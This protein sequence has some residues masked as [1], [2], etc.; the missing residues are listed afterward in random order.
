MAKA[1][2]KKQG[3][4]ETPYTAEY[5]MSRRK[6]MSQDYLEKLHI[7]QCCICGK[8]IVAE[9]GNNPWPIVDRPEDVYEQPRETWPVCCDRCDRDFVIPARYES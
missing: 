1:N 4:I 6:T 8:P 7:T 5:V 3:V 2:V 9:W